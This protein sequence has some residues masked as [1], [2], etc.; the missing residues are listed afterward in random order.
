M[1]R[2]RSFLF[3]LISIALA[4][5][6]IKQFMAGNWA[7]IVFLLFIWGV[8]IAHPI[9][10]DSIIILMLIAGF[11]VGYMK[12]AF[13]SWIAYLIPEFLLASAIIVWLGE[14]LINRLP[15]FPQSPLTKPIVL[16]GAYCLVELL[17]PM[18]P[19][20]R[21]LAGFRS[22]IFYLSLYFVGFYSLKDVRQ[23]QKIYF[24][25]ILLGTV[26][27]IYGIWQWYH[28][29]LIAETGGYFAEYIESMR[30]IG[31]QG[32]ILRPWSTFVLPGTFG[33]NM[34]LVMLIA[35][36]IFLSRE[37][38]FPLRLLLL[39]CLGLM[40]AGLILSGSRAPFV[41]LFL[42][43]GTILFLKVKTD[44]AS[45]SLLIVAML[46]A[47]GSIYFIGTFLLE[48]YS[49]ILTP[50]G[51]FWKW[52][53]PLQRGF[54]IALVSPLGAGLGYTAGV[55]GYIRS[56]M[57]Q[58][59]PTTNID[60]GLGAAAAELGLP[61]FVIFVYFLAKLGIESIKSWKNITSES[62]KDL[63]LAPASYGVIITITSVIWL[64]NAS[65]PKSMYQWFLIGML[66]KAGYLSSSEFEEDSIHAS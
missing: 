65:L 10:K 23:I 30:W 42:G 25:L 2:F 20:L 38:K 31:E 50:Q 51:F 58:E 46:A 22:W 21:S 66:M 48:R 56:S 49:T 9:D 7:N 60:S 64:F 4:L 19:L 36:T 34:A 32:R 16:L 54:R 55:P 28:P 27:A 40:G 37:I 15:I 35:F 6:L 44:I 59:L 18:S 13:G 45:I 43:I 63:L 3:L 57:L 17:N 11:F 26:T 5:F 14:C 62:M 61:G 33:T 47:V 8:I 53:L 1:S 12:M 29:S 52:A 41:A 24:F 39:P